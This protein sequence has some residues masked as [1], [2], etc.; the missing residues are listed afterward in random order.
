MGSIKHSNK[1]FAPNLFQKA[2]YIIMLAGISVLIS[3]YVIM[4]SDGEEYGY[5]LLGLT[6]GPIV[7]LLG[8][9]TLFFSIFK[10]YQ[11]NNEIALP[12][13]DK[14]TM[15]PAFRRI[16]AI[17]GWIIFLIS[18]SVYSITAEP[19][20]SLWDCGEFISASY[21]LQIPHPPGTPLFLL[22]GR[23]FSLFAP[24]KEWIAFSINM[25]SVV[26]SSFTILI[27]FHSIIILGRRFYKTESSD[28]IKNII[29]II[30]ASIGSLCFAFSDSFWFNATEA[31]VYALSCL[32]TALVFW[33][34]LKWMEQKDPSRE[35]KW[36]LLLAYL[37]G[38]SVGVHLLNLVAI[39]ALAFIFY[40][41][42]YSKSW[43]GILLTF[44]FSLI[45][46]LFFME[47]I[48]IGI[49]STAAFFDR[50]FVNTFSMP[51]G[52]GLIIF[53]ITLIGLSA[54]GL[55]HS[56][57]SEKRWMQTGMLALI[58][59][60]AGSSSNII[61]PIRSAYNPPIDE[62]DPED[63]M[64]LVLYLKRDQ[65]GSRPLLKGPYFTAGYPEK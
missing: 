15:Q 23:F 62:N 40:F 53:F 52:S 31:E 24:N 22:F 49:P 33:T 56:L 14:D 39:P 25:V 34:M 12:I 60:I 29:L 54:Y 21:K 9:T 2:N 28:N 36:L 51:F 8:F 17:S 5:G 50:I 45:L 11:V 32:F 57:K 18:L 58:F 30:A 42:K 37:I 19:T 38:L 44:I 46:I 65:Y 20:V 4:A 59:T 63:I 13:N 48:V 61:I 43:K 6:I 26:A 47:G 27:L 3:G 10:N 16:N 64:S 35:D 1:K 41:K 7:V 55:Y